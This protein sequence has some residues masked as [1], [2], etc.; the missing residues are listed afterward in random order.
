MDNKRQTFLDKVD[1]RLGGLRRRKAILVLL[2]LKRPY[3]REECLLHNVHIAAKLKLNIVWSFCGLW[4][5]PVSS[6]PPPCTEGTLLSNCRVSME[7]ISAGTSPH[8]VAPLCF[9]SDVW[10]LENGVQLCLTV[11]D[12]LVLV[13]SST[14][15]RGVGNVPDHI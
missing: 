8:T 1:L 13:T 6:T 9:P 2:R 14:M 4:V 7:Y 15:I 3:Q 12:T 11:V 10:L 5:G